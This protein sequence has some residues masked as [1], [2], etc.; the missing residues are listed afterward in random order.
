MDNL[1]Q[2]VTVTVED[3]SDVDEEFDLSPPSPKIK[4]Y[5]EAIQSLEDIQ[6]FLESRGCLKAASNVS[7]MINQVASHH[8]SSITQTTLD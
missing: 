4:S 8:V 5:R 6:M 3:E 1:A 7:S 2:E